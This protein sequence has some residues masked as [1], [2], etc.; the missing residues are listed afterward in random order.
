MNRHG[1]LL[2]ILSLTLLLQGCG[3]TMKKDGPPLHSVDMSKVHNAVPKYEPK[4][5]YGNPKSY[6]ALGKRYYVL[7]TAKGYDQR[8][9]ASWY[10]TKFNGQLTSTREPYDMLSMTAASPILPLPCY[11]RVTNLE[12][13]R[14][15]VVRVNDR[16]PFAPNR[17]IDLSYV[18]A[19]KLGY[20]RKGTALVEVKAIDPRH[21]D[22]TP[23]TVLTA[24]PHLYL[25]VGAFAQ[26]Q[27]ASALKQ[28][29]AK[30]INKPIRISQA[31]SHHQ[32]IFRVRIG[33]LQGVGESDALFDKL[34][35]HG[36]RS[37]ITV[38]S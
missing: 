30:Y 17:I 33:P 18:A 4:S 32:R 20:A 38:I 6:V 36:L 35:R 9:I 22:S 5:R 12:N 16:G 2:T 24:N 21:P 26:E 23:P 10:G 14:S 7:P 27:H 13:G 11:V 29:L 15:I 31:I 28:R 19:K 37:A 8:G 1:T 34:H 25:Q 3:M